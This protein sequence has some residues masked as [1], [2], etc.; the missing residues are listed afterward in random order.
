MQLSKSQLRELA[1][2]AVTTPGVKIT[3]IP[4]K[5]TM[6][7]IRKEA[8]QKRQAEYLESRLASKIA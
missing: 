1:L 8:A 7:D 2:D 3:V 5:R 6:A 4:P